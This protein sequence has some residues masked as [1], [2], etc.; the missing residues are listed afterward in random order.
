[1]TVLIQVAG[2][3]RTDSGAP[4]QSVLAAAKA[5][6]DGLR[7]V[8]VGEDAADELFLKREGLNT[9]GDFVTGPL[10]DAL[11]NARA[12]GHVG[13]VITPDPDDARA[14]AKQG[15]NVFLCAASIVTN[16]RWRPERKGWGEIVE[17]ING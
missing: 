8:F 16:P 7:V 3:L 11:A 6:S 9:Y 12:S 1:M 4:V 14:I 10:M 15:V 5:L 13:L 17:E 2:V